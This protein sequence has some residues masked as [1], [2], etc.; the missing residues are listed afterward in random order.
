MLNIF[1][2]IVRQIIAINNTLILETLN[3][4]RIRP[5]YQP[6]VIHIISRQIKT[7]QAG[8]KNVVVFVRMES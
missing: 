7:I 8:L 4:R 6:A 2:S 3:N 5:Q 1:S